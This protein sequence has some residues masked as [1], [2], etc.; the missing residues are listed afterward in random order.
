[1]VK[2]KLKLVWD[3]KALDQFREIL[4]FLEKQS[5]QAPKIVKSAVITR[6][7]LIKTNP[8]LCE[9]DKLKDPSNKEFR[10]FVVYSYRVT[11][12]IK[13]AE[14]EIRILRIRHTSR[15]PLGY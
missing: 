11:Y 3:R 6:L 10:A 9:S 1:M 7:E 13:L 5:S 15:E 12:H 4:L 2:Q 8:N 14:N